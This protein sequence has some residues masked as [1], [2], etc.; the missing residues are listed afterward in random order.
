MAK[1]LEINQ[2]QA[3][4]VPGKAGNMARRPVPKWGSVC[5]IEKATRDDI[6]RDDPGDSI[7][8]VLWW[9]QEGSM[10]R[11][12]GSQDLFSYV[13]AAQEGQLVTGPVTYTGTNALQLLA[14]QGRYGSI[15]VTSC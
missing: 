4:H 8:L 14:I 10:I 13:E 2:R 12:G 6:L 5:S 9:G 7:E 15:L 11:E 1:G 3:A